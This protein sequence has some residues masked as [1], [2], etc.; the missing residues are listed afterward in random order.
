M[1][2]CG[3]QALIRRRPDALVGVGRRMHTRWIVSRA[4]THAS[5]TVG[6]SPCTVAL[7]S[8]PIHAAVF[9]NKLYM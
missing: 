1:S 4:Y 3:G 7:V 8:R 5:D 2:P 6:R 9:R